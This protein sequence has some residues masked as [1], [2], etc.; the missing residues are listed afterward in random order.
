MYDFLEEILFI[1]TTEFLIFNWVEITEFD[2]VNFKLDFVGY[3]P[4]SF[5]F[6]FPSALMAHGGGVRRYGER[7]DEEK[8]PQGTE[9]KAITYSAM[10]IY[11]PSPTRKAEIFVIV[12]I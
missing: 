7:W 8:H 12:D 3:L 2:P 11:P 9:V 5:L 6:P 1:F 10:K 4:A